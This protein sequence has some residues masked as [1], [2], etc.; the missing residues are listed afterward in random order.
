MSLKQSLVVSLSGLH[1]VGPLWAAVSQDETPVPPCVEMLAPWATWVRLE[2]QSSIR[3]RFALGISCVCPPWKAQRGQTSGPRHC[4]KLGAASCS[5]G[6]P[7]ILLPKAG[8]GFNPF[9]GL[10]T[11]LKELKWTDGTGII[12]LGEM[13]WTKQ[14]I[15]I[16]VL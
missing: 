6:I 7:H 14:L 3:G 5:Q 11:T 4:T 9:P 8:A 10:S 1:R 13:V 12:F 2:L 16:E 15:F